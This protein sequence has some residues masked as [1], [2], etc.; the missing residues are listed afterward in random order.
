MNASSPKRVLIVGTS[1]GLGVFFVA[2]A[3]FLRGLGWNTILVGE[4]ISWRW[5]RADRLAKTDLIDQLIE[6]ENWFYNPTDN[7]FHQAV[8]R[9]YARRCL[10]NLH[11]LFKYHQFTDAIIWN[12]NP[13]LA[14]AASYLASQFGVRVWYMENGAIPGTLQLDPKGVNFAGSLTGLTAEFYRSWPTLFNPDQ[15]KIETLP[16]RSN[17]FGQLEMLLRYLNKFGFWW[18]VTGI[19]WDNFLP[20]QRGKKLRRSLPTPNIKLP[21]RFVLVPLQVQDDTQIVFH[22]PQIKNM[23]ELVETVYA[24]VKQVEPNL[25]IIIK[26]HPQDF[27]RRD[28]QKLR[29]QYPDLIWLTRYPIDELLAR[30]S[31]VVV[32]NSGTG[33]EALMRHRPVIT[34]GEAFYNVPGLVLQTTVESLPATLRQAVSQPVDRDLID[35]FL[36]YMQSV[37]IPGGWAKF[38]PATF[39]AIANK[40]SSQL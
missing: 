39:E 2:L 24:A 32:I 26:E 1:P 4:L 27:G 13:T 28:Y 21:D 10:G 33:V 9:A 15:L 19:F 34:L 31:V 20:D 6:Y 5:W 38:G 11:L 8:L 14:K 17:R 12:G 18:S 37:N 25:P 7:K 30:A 3:K 23:T 22:S 35:R 29:Q 16:K 36:G 40:L